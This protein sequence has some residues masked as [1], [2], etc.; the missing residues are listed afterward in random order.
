[1]DQHKQRER[2]AV[3][4]APR[5]FH[6]IYRRP[7]GV[8]LTNQTHHVVMGTPNQTLEKSVGRRRASA[9]TRLYDHVGTT[10]G[11]SDISDTMYMEP[12]MERWSGR[13]S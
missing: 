7:P 1:M 3:H 10:L 12:E 2:E 6:T 4:V 9:L 13:L 5:P 11:E 8:P